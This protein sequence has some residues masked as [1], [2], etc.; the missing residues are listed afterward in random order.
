MRSLTFLSILGIILI[1]CSHSTEPPLTVPVTA[2]AGLTDVNLLAQSYN[3]GLRFMSVMSNNVNLDGLSVTWQYTYYYPDTTIPPKLYWFHA[4]SIGVAFDSTSLMGVG[5]AV[6]THTWFNSDLAMHI[7][8]QN[9][10][11]Q[12]R[13]NNP[14]YVIAASVGEPVVP[15][16]TTYWNIGYYSNNDKT[17]FLLLRIDANTGEVKTYGSDSK[18]PSERNA[19]I[20]CSD[21]VINIC[22]IYF[23]G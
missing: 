12:F 17:K 9:G 4:N 15:N 23:I 8:E 5:S 1:G 22:R 6:I 18:Q 14:N 13:S 10:G 20:H 7:A 21:A 3:K 11:S 2:A 19:E 16:P